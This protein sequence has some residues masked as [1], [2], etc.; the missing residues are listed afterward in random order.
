MVIK[1]IYKEDNVI[2][3]E[4]EGHPTRIF[5]DNHVGTLMR[6]FNENKKNNEQE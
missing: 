5:L 6:V 2:V 4:I 3:M 1:A